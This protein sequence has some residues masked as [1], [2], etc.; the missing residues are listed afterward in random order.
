MCSQPV[1]PITA[2]MAVSPGPAADLVLSELMCLYR[3]LW[4]QHKELLGNCW[5]W[6]G[7]G[8]LGHFFQVESDQ[9]R[10]ETRPAWRHES[11]H[12][13][14]I[15]MSDT[16]KHLT[17]YLQDGTEAIY[18]ILLQVSVCVLWL[19]APHPPCTHT[20]THTMPSLLEWKNAPRG[21]AHPRMQL[22][23]SLELW[24]IT[25]G[26]LKSLQCSDLYQKWGQLEYAP[27]NVNCMY[28]WIPYHLVSATPNCQGPEPLS[29][30]KPKGGEHFLW[31]GCRY[32]KGNMGNN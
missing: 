5:Q 9:N 8:E 20:N 21:A 11:K 15:L 18:L 27:F 26:N 23:W 24:W 25:V 1:S 14:S 29:L 22:C 31:L 3:A 6:T 16:S 19:P 32:F 12:Q 13:L 7:E 17:I 4:S 28:S 10:C 2:A 30:L